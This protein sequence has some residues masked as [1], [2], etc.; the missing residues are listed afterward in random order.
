MILISAKD[1]LDFLAAL[2]R[3]SRSGVSID[4]HD[5]CY[6]ISHFH[7]LGNFVDDIRTAIDLEIA[8]YLKQKELS[9]E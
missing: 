6:R 3:K 9:T 2:A 8:K 7:K 4:T 5:R 1:R